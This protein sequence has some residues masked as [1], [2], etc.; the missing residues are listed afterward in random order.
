M[1]DHIGECSD[2]LLLGSEIG[3][4]LELEVTDGTRQRQVAVDSA[5]VDEATSGTDSG[6]FSYMGSVEHE[7]QQLRGLTF[8]L[9]L[10]VERQRLRSTFH[11]KD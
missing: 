2:N 7:L 9:W 10:V 8:V 5:E 4:L 1:R 6:L 3:T 11:T